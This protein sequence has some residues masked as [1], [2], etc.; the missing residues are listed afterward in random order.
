MSYQEIA[1]NMIDKLPEDKL[2]FFIN[3]LEN[4]GEMSGVQVY[5][6]FTPNE[7]TE[8]AMNEIEKMITSGS[9]EHFEGSTTDFFTILSEN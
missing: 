1:K 8:S 6:E 3:I 9:G 5:P 7:E 2:V 4:I